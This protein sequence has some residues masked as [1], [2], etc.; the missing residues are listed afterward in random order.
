[1]LQSP[2]GT[3]GVRLLSVNFSSSFSCDY[4]QKMRDVLQ[5]AKT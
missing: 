3:S 5:S 4:G 1:L 2:Y